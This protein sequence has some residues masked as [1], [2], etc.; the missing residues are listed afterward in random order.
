M[1][2]TRA[3]SSRVITMTAEGDAITGETFEILGLTGHTDATAADATKDITI[4]DGNDNPIITFRM[5]AYSTRSIK[6]RRPIT[7]NGIKFLT[8]PTNADIG[9]YLR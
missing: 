5:A 3:G 9:I 2:V 8:G 6:V 7:A 1:A 4:S